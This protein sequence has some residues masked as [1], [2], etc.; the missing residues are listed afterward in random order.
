MESVRLW[1]LSPRWRSDFRQMNSGSLRV[2][3]AQPEVTLYGGPLGSDRQT[4]SSALARLPVY[5][6]GLR[7]YPVT[8]R[9]VSARS[10][11]HHEHRSVPG[12]FP[13]RLLPQCNGRT[14]FRLLHHY[15][16]QR[17]SGACEHPCVPGHAVS[18]GR[19]MRG[20]GTV[21]CSHCM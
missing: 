17:P 18:T 20:R 6:S 11:Q 8:G 9:V 3:R 5:E 2:S 13:L 4:D 19:C 21:R 7:W 12:Q 15:R 16:I 10:S 1:R 14:H